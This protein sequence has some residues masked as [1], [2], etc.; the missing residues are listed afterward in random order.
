MVA[1][2]GFIFYMS[3]LSLEDVY[4]P[5]IWDFDKLVHAVAYAILGILWFRA[6]KYS[7]EIQS[8]KRIAA[9]AFIVVVIYGISDEIHQYFVPYRSSDIFDVIADSVG[10]FIGIWFYTLLQKR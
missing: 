10:G 8:V 6:I 9:M 3:S 4:L 2:M 5:D 7:F 1:Y